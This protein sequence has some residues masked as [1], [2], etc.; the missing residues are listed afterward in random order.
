MGFYN[1]L[2]DFTIF[3]RLNKIEIA[4]FFQ[5]SK[6]LLS[7]KK[8][9][10]VRN[11]SSS[12]VWLFFISNLLMVLANKAMSGLPFVFITRVRFHS[13]NCKYNKIDPPTPNPIQ[14]EDTQWH[15]GNAMVSFNTNKKNQ[16][17][18]LFHLEKQDVLFIFL[19]CYVHCFTTYK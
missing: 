6:L 3:T 11:G 8:Y 16:F 18:V 5:A 17:I 15:Q 2:E 14:V 19:F 9:Q 10:F 12:H 13:S 7:C 1:I 4:F